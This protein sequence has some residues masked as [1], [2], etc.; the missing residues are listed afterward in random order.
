MPSLDP[1]IGDGNVIARIKLAREL[2]KK[3]EPLQRQTR[4]SMKMV[5]EART[6]IAR[7]GV[8]IPTEPTVPQGKVPC[9]KH[10]FQRNRSIWR[11]IIRIAGDYT[12]I[13][14]RHKRAFAC[15]LGVAGAVE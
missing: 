10:G 7:R 6:G 15:R 14:V 9:R 11:P 3:I 2:S 8:I 5:G 4:R 12:S 1:E 13:H